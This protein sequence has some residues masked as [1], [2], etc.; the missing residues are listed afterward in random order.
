MGKTGEKMSIWN[1][2]DFIRTIGLGAASLTVPSCAK[3]EGKD[4]MAADQGRPNV[5]FISG[6]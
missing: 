3:K 1:R 5:L 6:R 4:S 2:R